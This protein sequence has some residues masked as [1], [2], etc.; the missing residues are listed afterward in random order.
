MGDR[1]VKREGHFL[2]SREEMLLAKIE[3]YSAD[4]ERT[5]EVAHYDEAAAM[6]AAEVLGR[7]ARRR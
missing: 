2:S 1:P 3:L 7:G 4:E 5:R 6:R